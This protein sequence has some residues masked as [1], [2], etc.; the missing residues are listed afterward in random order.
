MHSALMHLPLTVKIGEASSLLF[1]RPQHAIFFMNP[2]LLPQTDSLVFSTDTKSSLVS[3]FVRLLSPLLLYF[4]A[5]SLHQ[6][7]VLE[8][9]VTT[10]SPLNSSLKRPGVQWS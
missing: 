9:S 7:C 2:L 3:A 6:K 5:P 10:P 4:T 1:V 8:F